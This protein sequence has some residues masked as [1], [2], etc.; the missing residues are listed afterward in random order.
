MEYLADTGRAVLHYA[1]IKIL[2]EEQKKEERSELGIETSEWEGIKKSLGRWPC[3]YGLNEDLRGGSGN[4]GATAT[5]E[6]AYRFKWYAGAVEE[7]YGPQRV[8]EWLGKLRQVPYDSD[9]ARSVPV[10]EK[11]EVAVITNYRAVL[12]E[13]GT[14]QAKE[15]AWHY[16]QSGGAPH[17]PTWTATCKGASLSVRFTFTVVCSVAKR[18]DGDTVDGQEYGRG[19]GSSKQV[20][21]EHAAR[22][23]WNS[24]VEDGMDEDSLDED[25][26]DEDSLDEDSMDDE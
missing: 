6:F 13:W 3:E 15:V 4:A 1:L 11:R 23:T 14:R 25:S 9:D 8:I 26:M 24:L 21:K 18:I 17:M 19:E 2:L 7:R 22:A 16:E 12:N 20:A 5:E 10:G